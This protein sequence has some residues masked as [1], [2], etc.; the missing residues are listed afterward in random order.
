MRRTCRTRETIRK[1][2]MKTMQ[3]QYLMS[4]TITL[5][6]RGAA[7]GLLRMKSVD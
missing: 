2:K 5:V 3:V 7:A 4:Y 1:S 6:K